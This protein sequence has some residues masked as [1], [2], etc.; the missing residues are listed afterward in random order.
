MKKVVFLF[1]LIPL[2]AKSQTEINHDVSGITGTDSAWMVDLRS[3]GDLSIV[4]EFTDFDDDDATLDVYYADIKDDES[5]VYLEVNEN[6]PM[7]L[8][9]TTYRCIV[10]DD[11]TSAIGVEAN[12]WKHRELWYKLTLGSV[13]EGNLNVII[14]K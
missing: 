1:L 12:K 3:K 5:R 11:T 10:N 7:T 2:L 6:F 9:R 13:T 14:N 8:N 4:F